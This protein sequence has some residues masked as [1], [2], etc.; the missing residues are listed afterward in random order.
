MSVAPADLASSLLRSGKHRA[1]ALALFTLALGTALYTSRLDGT[2][3]QSGNEAMYTFPPLQMLRTGD[4]LVPHYEHGPFL[5]KPP[6][7]WWIL[8]GSYKIFGTTIFAARLP[9]AIAALLTILVVAVWA[10]RRAGPSAGLLTALVL[11]YSFKFAAFAREFAADTF[12][13]LAVTVAVIALDSAARDAGLPDGR[14]G[15]LAGLSLALAF[16]F[17]GLIGVVLPL[18]GVVTGLVLD[19]SEPERW[20]R[21]APIAAATFLLAVAPWHIAMSL[22]FGAEFW[23]Q[24]YW[25]NQLLRGATAVYEHHSPGPLYYFGVLALATFPWIL[26]LPSAFRRRP[27]SPSAGGSAALGWLVF[28][29]AFLSLLRSKREVYLMPV[30]P[31]VAL[32]IGEGLG[33][34]GTSG[35]RTR[36]AWGIAGVMTAGTVLLWIRMAP[37]LTS[38]AGGDAHAA[39]GVGLVALCA[40][41]LATATTI[42]ARAGPILI[43]VACGLLFI[44]IL[45]VESRISRFDPVPHWG[46]RVRRECGDGCAGL[47]LKLD[48]R[49]LALYTRFE[50]EEIGNVR[51]ISSRRPLSKSFL[52]L[53][54]ADEEKLRALPVGYRVLDRR[55]W[56]EQN[57]ILAS[58]RPDTYPLQSLSLVALDPPGETSR[59]PNAEKVAGGDTVHRRFTGGPHWIRVER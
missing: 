22:R 19:R 14:A 17:K 31:A 49:S 10:R 20:K 21:R 59:R 40:S 15:A 16:A 1:L 6:L 25:R 13:T 26:L 24:F 11:M 12:L 57:W 43:S 48:F 37:A 28:G 51:E 29:F 54:S 34:E 38:L 23:E 27:R 7:T 50:W 5:E 58:L 52:I 35:R 9:G 3:I 46:R 53:R 18:G 45:I 47:L 56:L 8:A 2:P 44:A 32:L 33:S 30:L 4:Y 39:L 41:L 42:R 36:W 55:L